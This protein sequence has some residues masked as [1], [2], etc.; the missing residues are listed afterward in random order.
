MGNLVVSSAS[1]LIPT[2][3]KLVTSTSYVLPNEKAWAYLEVEEQSPGYRGIHRYRVIYVS[4]D[5]NDAEFHEDMGDAKNF[6][7]AKKAI[8]IPSLWEHTVAELI[9]LADDLRYEIEMD[10]K[11]YLQLDKVN[12]A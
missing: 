6:K 10:Y 3:S 7:G 11:D 12:L 8:H 2:M 4:R 5:G 1:K 9:A